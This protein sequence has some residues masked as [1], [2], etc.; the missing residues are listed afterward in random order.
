MDPRGPKT[1]ESYGFGSG[2]LHFTLG[3]IDFN[4]LMGFT[5]EKLPYSI[6]NTIS[7]IFFFKIGNFLRICIVKLKQYSII[8]LP[9]T[10]TG[11]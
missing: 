7:K 6:L 8:Q 1:Y 11:T 4:N 10:G 3:Y 5:S 2:T 9:Y